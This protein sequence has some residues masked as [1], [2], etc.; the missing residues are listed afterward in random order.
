MGYSSYDNKDAEV[1]KQR[2]ITEPVSPVVL[3][4]EGTP[5]AV[6]PTGWKH[7]VLAQ[8]R[9]TRLVQ[10]APFIAASVNVLDHASF[11]AYIARFDR[12]GLT[13]PLVFAD[14]DANQ[15]TCR[16]D[17]HN[18]EGPQHNAHSVTRVCKQDWR[19][20][21][22][23]GIDKKG[24]SQQALLE[25]LQDRSVDVANNGDLLVALRDFRLTIDGSFNAAH[26]LV[27]GNVEF[28]FTKNSA[29]ISVQLPELLKLHLPVF[30]GGQVW[31]IDARLKYRLLDGGKISF[32]IELANLREVLDVAF[33]SEVEL[34]A[35][36]LMKPVIMLCKPNKTEDRE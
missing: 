6:L 5:V 22:W 12:V 14:P 1:A 28:G 3:N 9:E 16:F 30:E 15:I 36:D 11:L 7:E 20:T 29:Q 13:G 26:N 4:I 2:Q 34:V 31:P 18:V 8:L 19:L 25:F 10:K 27:N 33:R 21:Q 17:Y 23:R 24:I 32:I 35:K